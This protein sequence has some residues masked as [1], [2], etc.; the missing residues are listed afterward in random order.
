MKKINSPTKPKTPRFLKRYRTA[1]RQSNQNCRS[2]A[3]VVGPTLRSDKKFAMK[4]PPNRSPVQSQSFE[5]MVTKVATTST[6]DG[7]EVSVLVL[8]VLHHIFSAA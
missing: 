1:R 8:S 5:E 7:E 6:P 3:R 4:C 2:H